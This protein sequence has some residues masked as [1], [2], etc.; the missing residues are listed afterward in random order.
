MCGVP[1][2]IVR[3]FSSKKLRF[4]HCTDQ[5]RTA[6]SGYRYRPDDTGL[7]IN[8][9]VGTLAS[10]VRFRHPHFLSDITIFRNY[11]SLL[12]AIIAVVFIAK[13][14]NG[15]YKTLR[16]QKIIDR[17]PYTG[18]LGPVALASAYTWLVTTQTDSAN[19]DQGYFLPTGL[20]V[21][22]LAIP[23]TFIW[24]VGIKAALQ[25]SRYRKAVKGIIYQRAIS[26]LSQG[27]A[28]IIII[29]ILLQVLTTLSETLN[30]LNLGPL[31]LVI[32]I[33][34]AVYALGYGM[35]ARGAKKLKQIEEA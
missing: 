30:R 27:V 31:L 29:S 8:A 22:T 13:G 4:Q 16:N 11:L 12:F 26:N 18:F 9:L 35:V 28:F 33:L 24:C 7:P 10:Y 32:Y 6:L 34:V 14:A 15:L 3:F 21:A 5:R 20:V 17:F 1:G 2:G 19:A 25:L 23:Y